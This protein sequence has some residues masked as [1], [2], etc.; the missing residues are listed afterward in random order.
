MD[1]IK[2]NGEWNVKGTSP[3]GEKVEIKGNV[4]GSVLN[5][6]LISENM[7]EDI[8]WRNNAENYRKY[9]KYS[10]VYSKT[11]YLDDIIE[12]AEIVF[13]KLDT[14]ADI[15]I[16]GK[17]VG[18]SENAFI[19][20]KFDVS[21][22]LLAGENIVE[23]YFTSPVLATKAKRQR[24]CAFGSYERLYT[25]RP[26]CTYGWDWT[27]RFVTCGI[28]GNVY[29]EP[30][31]SDIEVSGVY[32][33]TENIDD[34]SAC[35][36]I[37]AELKRYEKGAVLDFEIYDSQNQQIRSISKYCEEEYIKLKADINE[38]ELWYPLGYGK[39]PIYTLN[40]KKN[41]ELL[42][43]Q[44]F[45][46]R[47]V[48]IQ[49]IVD[50][51]GSENYR[52]CI[53][54][55][56]SPWSQC[57]DE[58]D[59]FSGFILKVNGVK[60]M[61]KG[62]NWVP[63]EPFM[64]GNTDEK[65]TAT[66]ETAQAAGVNMIRVW[67]GGDF[68]T[69]HFYDE[70]SRLGIMVTQD[71]LM[72]CGTYPEDEKWFLEQ[73]SKEAEYIADKIR[74]KACLM[75]WSGDNENAIRGCDTDE[76]YNGRAVAH[77]AIAPVLYRKD[78]RRIFLASSPYGGRKYAS[79][80]TGTT[81][82]TQYLSWLW[83]YIEED[84]VENYK[85]FFKQFNAR[86]IAE[87]PCLGAVEEQT[88]KR[89]MTEEDIYGSDDKMWH[90]HT[91]SNPAL[92]KEIF[93]YICIFAEKLFGK[94]ENTKDR[95]FKI[96]Y[97]QYEWIRVSLERVRREKWF[98]S[99]V[100]YW[101]LN[102]CWP[103]ASGWSLIDYYGL[104]KAGYYSFKRA[105]KPIILSVDL[106]N[107][108]YKI[109]ISNDSI[110]QTVKLKWYQISKNGKIISNSEEIDVLV[111]ENSSFIAITIKE[112]EIDEDYMILAELKGEN[113]IY[114]RAFY[115]KGKMGIK[116]CN[117]RIDLLTIENGTVTVKAKAY[118][119]AVELNGEGLFEDNYFPLL[120]GEEK[121]VKFNSLQSD[122]VSVSAYIG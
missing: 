105:A 119:H 1:N 106:E 11:F 82:N 104:P 91:Q 58:N 90:Y 55:K 70:C 69:E 19:P 68:E 7:E 71:F 50:E 98:C 118:I 63:C 81:H 13:E 33:Y 61:C 80:T 57:Y 96:K 6:L 65:I 102:D 101:M 79:N 4:P 48:N 44:K 109:H 37:C 107:G 95:Y 34:E 43:S 32:I 21:G 112:N 46:I 94:F 76:N 49:E 100:I 36:G 18:R 2:L 10:W 8:F 41:G 120:P 22:L 35:I 93:E 45:G 117:D 40:V 108:E 29:I 23:V 64:R 26:Q 15:Y 115:K 84:D 92:R 20:H 85:E 24:N 83:R 53:E 86:F 9:E 87:E 51:K 110:A 77:K 52:K 121:T 54:L 31:S 28:N 111:N 25:R 97:L 73:I 30:I 116:S 72:A 39:Q 114:D 27:M 5:D 16:N 113:G 59:E 75:W 122:S 103:A 74:N 42:V 12:G 78:P 17:S 99:G 60:I 89:F 3:E 14:Y 47:T 62:A 88:L 66:L 38:P 67:G 56:K